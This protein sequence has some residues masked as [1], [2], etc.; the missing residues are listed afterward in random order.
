MLASV[1][2]TRHIAINKTEKAP[3]HLSG[4]RVCLISNNVSIILRFVNTLHE[5]VNVSLGTDASLIVDEDYGVS[6]Y[7]TVQRGE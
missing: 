7:R 3:A 2:G 6:A 5:E 4:G 1:L